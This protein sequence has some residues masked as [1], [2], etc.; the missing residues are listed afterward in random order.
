VAAA[1][2]GLSPAARAAGVD[3][4]RL[5]SFLGRAYRLMNLSGVRHELSRRGRSPDAIP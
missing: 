2:E 3:D 1:R 4:D 5:S